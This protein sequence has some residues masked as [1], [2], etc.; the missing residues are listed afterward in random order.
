MYAILLVTFFFTL[1]AYHTFTYTFGGPNVDIANGIAASTDGGFYLSGHT[2]SYGDGSQEIWTIKIT[3]AGTKVWDHTLGC[4]GSDVVYGMAPTLEGGC[5]VAGRTYCTGPEKPYIAKYSPD[6]TL[7]WEKIVTEVGMRGRTVISL[8]GGGYIIGGRTGGRPLLVK[9]LEDGTYSW[10]HVLTSSTVYRAVVEADNNDIVA[11]AIFGGSNYIFTRFNSAGDIQ[12]EFPVSVP[13]ATGCS[14]NGITQTTDGN[15]VAVGGIKPGASANQDT[16]IIKFDSNGGTVWSKQVSRTG[17]SE[18]WAVKELTNSSLVYAGVRSYDTFGGSD[19]G[20]LMTDTDGNIQHEINYGGSG[21]DGAYSICVNSQGAIGIGGTSSQS[22]VAKEFYAVLLY[23]ECPAWNY[24]DMTVYSC[25]PCPEGTFQ[26]LPEQTSCKDCH[27][28]CKNCYGPTNSECYHC[29]EGVLNLYED[30]SYC[31]CREGFFYDSIQTDPSEYCQPCAPFCKTC[32]E[33]ATNCQSCIDNKGVMFWDGTCKCMAD[34]YF[35]YANATTGIVECVTCH[36]LCASCYGPFN[37]Q[38]TSCD[39]SKGSVFNGADTCT[40]KEGYYYDEETTECLQCNHLCSSCFGGDPNQCFTCNTMVA[41]YVEDVPNLCVSDCWS[42]EGYYRSS[43]T[44]R[45]C[46]AD[47]KQC[48]GSDQN[49]CTQCQDPAKFMMNGTCV[50]ECPEHYYPSTERICYGNFSYNI[51]IECH[52]TCLDCFDGSSIGCINCNTGRYAWQSQCLESCPPKTYS[53]NNACINCNSPCETCNS[54][55]TC[56]S[57]RSPFYLKLNTTSCVSVLECPTGT[58]PDNSTQV[59]Q[60]C[61]ESCLECAGPGNDRCLT[62]DATKG[63]AKIQEGTGKC[64]LVICPTGYFTK[65]DAGK[66]EVTC[67]KCHEYCKSCNGLGP[68]FCTECMPGL[69][70]TPSQNMNRVTCKKCSEITPGLTSTE[71]GR[72]Q[73]NTLVS[74]IIEICG[75]GINLGQFQCDDGNNINGDGCSSDC[76]VEYGYSCYKREGLPDVCVDVLPP[77]AKLVVGKGNVLV[78]QFSESVVSKV[79]SDQL[80]RSME[81]RLEGTRGPCDLKWNLTDH[82]AARATFSTLTIN[83]TV[84]CSLKGK[85]EIFYV[86]FAEPIFVTDLEGNLLKTPLIHARSKRFLYI[87]PAQK[88]TTEATGSAFSM[89]S[90]LTFGIVIGINLLQSAA[91]GSF[92]AFINMLQILSY[93]PIIDC[94]LPY[95]LEVF[96]SEYLTVSK[97]AFPF[98][99]FAGYIP[100]PLEYISGYLINPFNERFSICGYESLSFIYNFFDQLLTWVLLFFF[101]MLLRFLTWLIPET[102]C[103]FIHRWKKEYEF[104]AVI[105]ILIECYL[106]LVFC[107]FLNIWMVFLQYF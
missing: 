73:G 103:K 101:Y 3:P 68:D 96:L 55:T 44:C 38:C 10:D 92:W 18:G 11:I 85:T 46:H 71:N 62:C 95:N 19:V 84:S 24:F 57:C 45:K 77:Q 27:K 23:E 70:S 98:Q 7:L 63:V 91:I 66:N 74:Y 9:I 14:F 30:L 4:S 1:K 75:D 49:D 39:S 40:C 87:S 17:G 51:T 102:K 26:D 67:V 15:F 76:T 5:V 97:V 106:N 28:L 22:G 48:V 64:S 105:R 72:C 107:S 58:Y 25:Q 94:E 29:K 8:R 59:C 86:T 93:I 81:V 80:S 31:A 13:G 37:T 33:T 79:D 61:H 34:D 35:I 43:G 41:Y 65:I 83:T 89:S 36:P 52:H 78:V 47:C 88:A 56:L 90:L 32:K 21:S 20:F 69:V 100:N 42:L 6:G 50:D 12:V 99:V 54:T 104:N 16:W 82:F 60:N 2:K 53:Y